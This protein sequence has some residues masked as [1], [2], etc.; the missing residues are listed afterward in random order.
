MII[1]KSLSRIFGPRPKPLDETVS[2][3]D[4]KL[5]SRYL[6]SI[7]HDYHS[8]S[9]WGEGYVSGSSNGGRGIYR[10]TPV[11]EPDGKPRVD[12]TTE[13]IQARAYSVPL[14]G[15]G[16]A[17]AG[18]ALG[19]G[20]GAL[21][22]HLTG[23]SI[24]LVGGIVGGV[25]GLAGAWGAAHYAAGD[26]VRLEWREQPI[27]EK[28]LAGYYHNVSPH[29]VQR[30]RTETDKDGKSTQHCWQEQQGWNHT[31]SPDVRYWKVGSHVAPKV[32]HFQDGAWKPEPD[33]VEKDKAEDKP[34]AAKA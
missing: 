21:I 33:P 3:E 27:N 30:C 24:G 8:Y 34:P 15:A 17:V 13:R 10:D 2:Y 28:R 26:N 5:Q 32:V 20:A 22:G 18:G 4:Q 23:A 9:S 16:G 12:V 11:Y 14:F 7:P 6:G 25:A 29:Y 31:F 19:F 1:Q